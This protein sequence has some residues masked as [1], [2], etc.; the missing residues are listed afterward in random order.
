MSAAPRQR[1]AISALATIPGAGAHLADNQAKGRPL[2][3]ALL[4]LWGQDT[5]YAEQPFGR[6]EGPQ[7]TLSNA[8]TEP[9]SVIV[10][11]VRPALGRELKS[12]LWT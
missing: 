7:P 5:T 10:L 12:G 6:A 2:R 4:R 8:G 3:G 11:M 9:N 1:R